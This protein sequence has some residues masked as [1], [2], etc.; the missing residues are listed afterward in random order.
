MSIDHTIKPVTAQNFLTVSTLASSCW[1][2]QYSQ[3]IKFACICRIWLSEI[4]YDGIYGPKTT[5][6]KRTLRAEVGET[7]MRREKGEGM[8]R[9]IDFIHRNCFTLWNLLW[10]S[11]NKFFRWYI[12][13]EL[14]A[15]PV[16]F[17]NYFPDQ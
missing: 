10:I 5:T 11:W 12:F 14:R 9:Y 3:E 2:T 16:V 15:L 8:E 13:I 1:F 4:R 6:E 17:Y 7:Q